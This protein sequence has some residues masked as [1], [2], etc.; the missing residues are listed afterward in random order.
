MNDPSAITELS[1]VTLRSLPEEKA[2]L[3]LDRRLRAMEES[4]KRSFIER[5][6]IL[7]EVQERQ[8]W[9]WMADETG[10]QYGSFEAW[11][12]NAAPQS[13]RD[14]FYAMRAIK[15]LQDIPLPELREIPRCN[16][17]LLQSISTGV[18]SKP[19]VIAAAKHLSEKE[20]VAKVEADWPDQHIESRRTIH[21]QPTKSAAGI[22]DQAI[23]M[24][25][26]LEG[27]QTREEALEAVAAYFVMGCRENYD[28]YLKDQGAA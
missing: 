2:A 25:T 27:C 23:E 18:R 11:V 28:K 16:I 10:L 8:L 22:I 26:A 14:C 19:E 1:L 4:Y 15:D 13:R 17:A 21:L 6:I 20:F 7:I 24:A 12:C 3:V 5:G 9:R